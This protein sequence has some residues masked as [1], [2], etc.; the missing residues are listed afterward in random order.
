MML[1]IQD[2][3]LLHL[4][5]NLT[6]SLVLVH[7]LLLI[8]PKLFRSVFVGRLASIRGILT[9]VA[10]FIPSVFSLTLYNDIN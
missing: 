10:R 4:K 1:V 8:V 3:L 7:H 6:N 9:A 2:K 5:E